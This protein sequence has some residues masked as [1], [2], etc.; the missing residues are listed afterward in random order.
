MLKSVIA[1]FQFFTRLIIP[2]RIENPMIYLKS[3]S[4]YLPIVGL[5]LG[6]IEG[7]V[8]FASSFLF[9]PVISF[10][11]MLVFNALFTGA[12][13]Q[14]GLAD[15]AD[16]LFSSRNKE[17]ML[18]IMKDSRIGT[19]GV[20]ALIFNYLFLIGIVTSYLDQF[21]G[22]N[23]VVLIIGM[24]IT[25][26]GS[27]TLLFYKLKYAGASLNGLGRNWENLPSK[28]ILIAQTLTVILLFVTTNVIGMLSYLIVAFTVLLYRR[29]V[30]SKIE[31]MN[32]DTI[33][34][35]SPISS[36]VFLLSICTLR[37]FL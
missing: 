27:M 18:S 33:G 37:S 19:M 36:I 14:D 31:G 32:G 16:G 25:S 24:N 7:V 8:F 35:I 12:M 26:K 20:L 4:K 17:K 34:A 3:G 21:L 6:M 15:M 1:Y 30:Y 11:I 9:P 2:I 5:V 10:I 23:G 22:L 29:H 13:H 28:D